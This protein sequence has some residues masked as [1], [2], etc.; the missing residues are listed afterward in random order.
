MSQET[1][2][3]GS[4]GPGGCS[5]QGTEPLVLQGSDSISIRVQYVELKRKLSMDRDK[6][7]FQK[8]TEKAPAGVCSSLPAEQSGRIVNGAEHLSL[9]P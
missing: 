2:W 3:K 8:G 6:R 1:S 7:L 9:V 4:W 5:P